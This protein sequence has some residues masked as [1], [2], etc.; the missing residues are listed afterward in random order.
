M[1]YVTPEAKSD[2]P[3]A[4]G[5]GAGDAGAGAA[6]AGRPSVASRAASPSTAAASSPSS[7]QPQQTIWAPVTI[8]LLSY[9]PFFECFTTFLTELYRVSVGFTELPIEVHP[10]LSDRWCP[11]SACVRFVQRYLT[12]LWETPLPRTSHVN[13]QLQ[14]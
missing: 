6:A 7:Q 8:C 5:P 2:A 10:K 13:V 11:D 9:W 3:A 1:W 14:V 4:A 12:N